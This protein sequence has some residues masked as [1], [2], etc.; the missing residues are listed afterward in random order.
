MALDHA[1]IWLHKFLWSII[2][3]KFGLFNSYYLGEGCFFKNSVCQKRYKNRGFSGLFLKNKNAR[4]FNSS[5]LGQ[6]GIFFEHQLGLDNN[7]TMA[8]IMPFKIVI[9][10]HFLLLKMC[11]NTYFIVFLNI[12]QN[13]PK[14]GPQKG[15]LSHF[16][17]HTFI[18]KRFVATPLLT[19]YFCF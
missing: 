8:Q 3:T 18:K 4:N 16:A 9:L 19:K 10:C 5:Y 12:N 6:V 11:W 14:K 2:W 1:D 7:P 15:W 17:K 13:L